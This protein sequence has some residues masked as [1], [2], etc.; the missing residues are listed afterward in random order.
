M[1]KPWKRSRTSILLRQRRGIGEE[2]SGQS[3]DPH[4]KNENSLSTSPKCHFTIFITGLYSISLA[5]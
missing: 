1:G 5:L 2:Q 3:V 4:V